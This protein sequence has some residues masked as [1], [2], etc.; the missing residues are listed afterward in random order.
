MGQG[1]GGILGG[2]GASKN[3]LTR[4]A[5]VLPKSFCLI[6]GDLEKNINLFLNLLFH[7]IILIKK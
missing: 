4:R 1:A 2:W 7:R 3:N 6:R 5:R